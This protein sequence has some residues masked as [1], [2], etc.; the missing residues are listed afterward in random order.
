MH[1][2]SGA[3]DG[4]SDDPISEKKAEKFEAIKNLGQYIFYHYYHYYCILYM[5]YC[6][7]F[8]FCGVIPAE[9]IFPTVACLPPYMSR[10]PPDCDE[11]IDGKIFK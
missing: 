1:H 2:I 3:T 5:L 4:G 9:V 6:F 8:L 11:A 10:T 7:K